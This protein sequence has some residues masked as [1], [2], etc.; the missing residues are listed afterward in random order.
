[1]IHAGIVSAAFAFL[2]W[3][4]PGAIGMY[5]LSL[6]VQKMPE[7]LQPL[8]YALLSGMNASTVGIIA[9]AAVQL[10]E[11]AIQDRITRVLVIFGACAGICYN[12][13]W[14]F[15]LLITLGGAMT[16]LW[17]VW[18]QQKIGK[19]RAGYPVRRRRARNEDG[20]AEEVI[21]T[22]GI[23]VEFR[24]P[25]ATQRRT[26]TGTSTDRIVSAQEDAG[27]SRVGDRSSTRGVTDNAATPIADTKTHNI[28]IK[29]GVSLIVAFVGAF[30]IPRSTH[31]L[32]AYSILHNYH[33][34]SRHCVES[35][36][37]L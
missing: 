1:M 21:A 17:D 8:V 2:L 18:L 29:V 19:I 28:S 10:A 34:D 27:P 26:H 14:Y 16:V 30:Y 15:P 13:L 37:N 12:A 24:R 5:G 22:R 33:G 3:S 25:E 20:D 9:L 36:P 11:K 32:T 4:L 23:P 31:I 35:G 7:K 6:G